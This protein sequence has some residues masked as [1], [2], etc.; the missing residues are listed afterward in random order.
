[1]WKRVL[2]VLALLIVLSSLWYSSIIVNR[3]SKEE[4]TK[5][6]LWAEAIQKKANLVNYTDK[7]FDKLRNEERKKVELYVEAIKRLTN[8]DP[9]FN[10][11][12]LF[13]SKVVTNNTTV[14]VI[15]VDEEKNIKTTRNLDSLI[16]SNEDS[17]LKQ[18]VIMAS[19]YEPI[20]I[21]YFGNQKDF[22][23]YKD[24]QLFSELQKV[25]KDLEQSFISEVVSN[26]V[27]VPVIYTDSS[28]T[29]IL[30]H[31]NLENRKV[32]ESTMEEIIMDMSQENPPIEIELTEGHYNYIFYQD[33]W[34]LTQL[35]Y[36]PIIQ[37]GVIGV[38][39][40]I[41]YFLFSNSRRAEQNQVWVGMAKETAHQLGT[42]LSSLMAWV[43]LMKAKN[44]DPKMVEELEKDVARLGTI[45]DRF[46]KIGSAPVLTQQNMVEV[47][48]HAIRYIKSR[49][50]QKVKFTIQHASTEDYLARVNIPLF[51]WV[52][53][54]LCKNAIDA[55][56]GDGSLTI[57]IGEIGNQIFIDVE[58]TGKGISP[59]QKKTVFQPG[60][61]TKKRG[62]GLGLS[63]S[64]RIIES[65]HQGKI[66][67]KATKLG[68]GTTFR[69][70][71]NK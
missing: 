45:T 65:Y 61:T 41:A 58:D 53:E 55:M 70:L 12:Y 16:S 59:S 36:Y 18:L 2:F 1:M 51:E 64:K 46:S 39:M 3:I 26:A 54:N 42:P 63:L 69:I 14:P 5:V 4:R 60:F 30:A 68:A 44:S 15:L 28:R 11:D 48:K 31:G 50:S 17:L 9:N 6:Q 22:V 32:D 67:V 20:E 10:P 7:L 29:R 43:E 57:Y 38:F 52:I 25:F 33:S 34:I 21:N 13:L 71:L 35:K 8:P 23:Y 62:W 56:E 66:W 19:K 24:S 27:S 37:F 40:L 47:I 49:S